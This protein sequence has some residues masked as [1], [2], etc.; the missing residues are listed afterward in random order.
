MQKLCNKIIATM[1]LVILFVINSFATIVCGAELIE[2]NI[3]TSE[4]NVTFNATIGNANS[5]GYEYSADIDS[6]DTVLNLSIDVKNT[7]Y[8]KDIF[9]ELENSN[10]KLDTTKVKS[11]QIKSISDSSIELNQINVG[12]NFNLSIPIYLEKGDKVEKDILN[13]ESKVKLKATYVNKDNREKRIQKEIKDH[14]TW[15]VESTLLNGSVNQNVIRYLNYN[16]KTVISLLLTDVLQ[17]YKL[18]VNSKEILVSVPELKNKKP[19]KVIVTAIDTANT[20]GITNGTQFNKNNFNY[21]EEKGIIKINVENAPDEEN[22]IAWNKNLEDKFII[23]YIYDI[24]TNEEAV[25]INTK[26][27]STITTINGSEVTSE[28]ENVEYNLDSKIGDIAEAEINSNVQTLNKGYMYTNLNKAEN[29]LETEYS[30]GYKLN[31]GLAEALEK[32]TLTE[33]G[34]Y[35]DDKDAENNIYTKKVSISKEEL[36]KIFG[37]NGFINVINH[38]EIIGTLNKDTLELETNSTKLVFETSKPQT[39]GQITINVIKSIKGDANYS[40]ENIASFK[41]LNTKI[42]INKETEN[43]ITLEEPTSKATIEISNTNL[44]T[45]VKNEDVIITAT[46]EKDDITDNLYKDPEVYIQLPEE[47]KEIN[48]KDAQLLYEDELVS[49]SSVVDGNLIKLSLKGT[50]TD[51]SSKAT[52]N[53][54]VIRLVT[55]LTLDNL[56]PSKTS[57]VLLGYKN[58]NDIEDNNVKVRSAEVNIVAPT[59]FVTTNAING[60]NGEETVTSQEGNE[61]IGKLP[62]LSNEKQATISGTIV[63]NLAEN[64]EG[65][66]ILGRIPFKGNKQVDGSIDLGSTFDTQLS[67]A[68]NVEGIESDVYYSENP[69]ATID[70]EN[71]Q[72]GWHTS[73]T[74]NDKSYLIVAKETVESATAIKFNYNVTIPARVDYS[75]VVKSSY[76]VYYNNN[77][78]EGNAKNVV[79]ATPVGVK[80]DS[81]SQMDISITAE[82]LFTGNKIEDKGNI[83]EG[84]YITCNVTIKN[85][86]TEDAVNSKLHIDLPNEMSIL[87]IIESEYPMFYKEYESSNVRTYE[88]ELGTIKAG[89]TK[90]ETLKLVVSGNLFEDNNEQVLRASVT[91]GNMTNEQVKIFTTN[92]QKGYVT[93][94]LKSTYEDR[95]VN[96]GQEINYALTI[97]NINL[98]EKNNIVAKIILPGEVEY[99]ETVADTASGQETVKYQ[100]QYDNRNNTVT[101]NIEK[102]EAQDWTSVFIKTKVKKSSNNAIKARAEITCKE[103]QDVFNTNQTAI[104]CGNADVKAKL[105]SNIEGNMLDTDTLE[106]YIELTNSS[107]IPAIV[108]IVDI[109][110]NELATKSYKL[111]IAGTTT[112]S[113]DEYF[114]SEVS[115]LIELGAKQ[116]A[117]LTIVTK[118]H[119]MPSTETKKV[120]N[121]P[122]AYLLDENYNQIEEIKIN[123]LTHTVEG[124]NNADNQS[125]L[126]RISG[127]VWIDANK[128]GK[129]EESE[130]RLSNI[131]LTLYDKSGNIVKDADGKER[132]IYT[133]DKG[134]YNFINLYSGNYIVVAEYD[135]KN[136][137]ATTYKANNLLD[138]EN[139]DFFDAKLGELDVAATDIIEITTANVYNMDLGL[140]EKEKFDLR[141]DKLVGKVTVTN[142]QMDSRV[143]EF[144]K[145]FVQ[146]PLYNT[147][148]EYSTVLI[149]YTIN[150]RNNGRVAG[151]AKE[152]VDYIPEGMA[153]SSDLNSN[154]Y[155][156]KDGNAYTTALANTLIEPGETKTVTLVLTRKMTGENVGLVHNVAEITKDYNEYGL[157]D[158]NSTPGNKQDGEDDMSYADTLLSMSTGKEV[159]SFIGITIGVLAI[160]ALAVYL[161]KKYIITKI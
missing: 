26:A 136:Y 132:I 154:W 70:L 37:E 72:N 16:E 158:G 8:L 85:T 36:I 109:I 81:T 108:K 60:Y 9:I 133:D 119:T 104:Y 147:Y 53:G 107:D 138:S 83:K 161:I 144:N 42:K 155:L 33:V 56:A 114:S 100:G 160:V 101:F 20:N 74:Q 21:D 127:T 4:E 45:V 17:D 39:E 128:D 88:K 31:I 146:V 63:N 152:I 91:A 14:L 35:F 13:R 52:S 97:Q 7:G 2:Q 48:V 143:Y 25:N 102:L 129:K 78:E 80:T 11:E 139:S 106:Y 54:S 51:Y 93:G 24:N 95:N 40:K 1:L 69:N 89:E 28:T 141:L 123:T 87:N 92:L 10:Y 68:V 156:G 140:K 124:T 103:T 43:T 135:T 50:Q 99:I 67:S 29:K 5:N 15:N 75:N 96:V 150:V 131:K 64:A 105:S 121:T 98:D 134:R 71:E 130:Q 18:P 77:S 86:S 79:L 126:Y 113:E 32:V 148:I 153:F 47:I 151:Y 120:T 84:G 46:L 142:T 122:K 19:S 22:K 3:L 145:Q 116:T 73:Y 76:G 112:I 38:N 66:A 149:E 118:P 61:K 6:T 62:V 27:V 94:I 58:Q 82:D 115:Q 157:K 117:R 111:E 49:E 34:S 159:A 65:F 110:P 23:T 57:N 90:T 137:I 44:S 41:T 59:G 125:G 30:L 55:D 12:K